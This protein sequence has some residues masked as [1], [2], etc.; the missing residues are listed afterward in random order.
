MQV[1][2]YAFATSNGLRPDELAREVE[3]RGFTRLMFP[4]HSHIPISRATSYPDVYGGGDL[5]DFYRQ[6]FD[7]FVSCTLSASATTRLRV[8]TGI[9]LLALR[10]PVNT[11]KEVASVDYLSGGR[12]DFGVGF[13][14]NAD[15]FEN[16]GVPFKGRQKLVREKIMLMRRLWQDD[17][18][19]Y[20]GELV[21]L[22]P[23]WAWPKPVGGPPILLGGNGPLTMKH[24]AEWADVWYPTPPAEDPLLTASVPAF[25]A[26]LQEAGRNPEDVGIGCAP[27]DVTS[28]DLETYAAN[29]LDFVNVG[30]VTTSRDDDLRRLDEVAERAAAY[31]QG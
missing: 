12:F 28:S 22:Q 13:G 11:A 21:S 24:A 6:T 20:Q 7:P 27:G 29:G 19:E 8:G 1:G 14:W 17:V 2:I 23:S 25:H 4:E 31:L 9:C 10:E 26:L 3:A 16:L 18:A 30:M 5:P 15:E